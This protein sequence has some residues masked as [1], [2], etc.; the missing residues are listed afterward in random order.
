MSR[1][2]LRGDPK[3]VG[4]TVGRTLDASI[5]GLLFVLGA[6][7][8]TMSL[9]LRTLILTFEPYAER[10]GAGIPLP[11]RYLS[12]CTEG[13]LNGLCISV[14]AVLV[15]LLSVDM[16][17][18]W[19]NADRRPLSW[20]SIGAAVLVALACAG[21]SIIVLICVVAWQ[22]HLFRPK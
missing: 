18:D 21:I 22:S 19:R 15:L 5:A 3:S 16:G 20:P 2:R 10:L 7:A 8:P 9:P 13:R 11:I 17:R 4:T 12:D 1:S 14:A 6:L